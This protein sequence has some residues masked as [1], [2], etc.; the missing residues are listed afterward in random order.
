MLVHLFDGDCRRPANDFRTPGIVGFVR[1]RRFDP[2]RRYDVVMKI[3][4]ERPLR[5]GLRLVGQA[6]S[7]R[8]ESKRN[9]ENHLPAFERGEQRFGLHLHRAT[10]SFAAGYADLAKNYLMFAF[11]MSETLFRSGIESSDCMS[12]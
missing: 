5:G 2:F 11:A 7:E 1:P 4:P 9:T 6:P 3:D 10:S 12:S 8:S